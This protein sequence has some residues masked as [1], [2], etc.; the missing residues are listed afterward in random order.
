MRLPVRMFLVA[1]IAL[2]GICSAA[3]A[4]DTLTGTVRG[5]VQ[6]ESG[7]VLPGVTVE[8]ASADGRV[9]ATAVTD[10]RGQYVF[11]T[12]PAGSVLI[13][14]QLEGFMSA[15]ATL[16][17][18]KG[19]DAQLDQHLAVAPLAE[20]VDVVGRAPV[21]PPPPPPLP[22]PP[23]VIPV[24]IHD[25]ESVCG[26]AKAVRDS[27]SPGTI[28]SHRYEAERVLY[29]KDDQVT[30]DGGTDDGLAPG[31]NLAVRRYYKVAAGN[32]AMLTGE[33]TAGVLQIVAAGEQQSTGVVVYACD[34]VRKGDF[35]AAFDP[36][37]ARAPDPP[38]IPAF[39]EAARILFAD[40]G[41]MLGVPRRLMVIDG[42]S[43]AGMHVGQRLTLFRRPGQERARRGKRPD[44]KKSA[45]DRA[46]APSI[47]G[48]AVV[49][50]V[51]G[52]SA[53][54]RVERATDAIAFGDWAAPEHSADADVASS[55]LARHR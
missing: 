24:P 40:A 30:I 13:T 26:P 20:T 27:G 55:S 51:R 23:S 38:G 5:A 42:G 25:R 49:V 4:A 35:L 18:E 15:A 9:L 44:G 19:S 3:V 31:Q 11:S 12:L 28:R 41:Q 37:P 8:A 32:G 7:G 39:D 17:I 50:A 34:E 47:I 43:D 14:F 36:E 33:H 16:A 29:T 52:D 2:F 10:E 21:D 54:I 22:P 53:T 46:Q 45:G 6:D 48:N 1:T